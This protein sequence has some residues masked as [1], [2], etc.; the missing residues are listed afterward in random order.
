MFVQAKSP[1]EFNSLSLGK[2]LRGM[3]LGATSDLEH[4]ALSEGT[5]SAGGYTV[6]TV[7]SAQLIDMLRADS[8]IMR[9]GAQAVPM[10][11]D[12]LSFAR[13]ALAIRVDGN[14]TPSMRWM[15]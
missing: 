15:P 7:L 8:V 2:Y 5:D 13:E 10:A 12:N 4:R 1:S 9:A 3:T 6:P 11:R 14:S